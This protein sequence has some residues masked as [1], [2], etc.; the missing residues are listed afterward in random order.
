LLKPFEI[1]IITFS[2]VNDSIKA[3]FVWNWIQN[4]VGLNR[5]CRRGWCNIPN[6]WFLTPLQTSLW[7]YSQIQESFSRL[8]YSHRP[9]MATV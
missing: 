3:D 8:C 5:G 6:S 2:V 9:I 7:Q 1:K 4:G